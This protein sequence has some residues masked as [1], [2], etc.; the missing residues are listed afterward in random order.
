MQILKLCFYLTLIIK[1]STEGKSCISCNV[2]VSGL[3]ST[4]PLL[5]H[6]MATL[7]SFKPRCK[8]TAMKLLKQGL[9]RMSSRM[10]LK[11]VLLTP[12]LGV[13]CHSLLFG[14]CRRALATSVALPEVWCYPRSSQMTAGP[15]AY[16]VLIFYSFSLQIFANKILS[17]S[18]S[19]VGY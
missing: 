13:C 17:S 7:S 14:V 4:V 8:N 18:I 5:I 16:N 11:N 2:D 6:S 19:L 1:L 12:S 10:S 15:C 9:S 3:T